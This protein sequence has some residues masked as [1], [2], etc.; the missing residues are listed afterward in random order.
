[1]GK[2]M[3][4]LFDNDMNYMGKSA[5][6]SFVVMCR[7]KEYQNLVHVNFI[8]KVPTDQWYLSAAPFIGQLEILYVKI[9]AAA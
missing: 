5:R 4:Q 1:M 8:Q 7:M 6:K 2:D 3:M 9:L